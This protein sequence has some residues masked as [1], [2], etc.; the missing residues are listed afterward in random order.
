MDNEPIYNNE[1]MR[2]DRKSSTL[3]RFFMIALLITAAFCSFKFFV[4]F[5]SFSDKYMKNEISSRNRNIDSS[6]VGPVITYNCTTNCKNISNIIYNAHWKKNFTIRITVTDTYGF[7]NNRLT[8]ENISVGSNL[9]IVDVK[10]ISKNSTEKKLVYDIKLKNTVSIIK[11]EIKT[12][13]K[14]KSKSF[15]NKNSNYSSEISI[16]IYIELYEN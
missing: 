16:P 3:T 10:F 4:N 5:K 11:K 6:S 15:V 14:L 13:V 9:N 8:S 2:N 12:Y 1:N 7:S